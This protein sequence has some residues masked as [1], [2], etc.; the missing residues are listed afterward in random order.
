M[1]GEEKLKGNIEIH[2]HHSCV[3]META[4]GDYLV[5]HRLVRIRIVG[6]EEPERTGARGW[7]TWLHTPAPNLTLSTVTKTRAPRDN[8]KGR[9]K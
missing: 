4:H 1:R 6:R 8:Q 5:S 9:G 3:I 2:C 7:G